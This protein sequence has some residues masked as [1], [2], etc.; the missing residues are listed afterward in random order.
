MLVL[1]QNLWCSLFLPLSFEGFAVSAA[2]WS[3]VVS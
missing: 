3:D 2:H 1:F